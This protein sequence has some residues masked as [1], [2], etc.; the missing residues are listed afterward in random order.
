M[1]QEKKWHRDC[2][3][4]RQERKQQDNIRGEDMSNQGH[5]ITEAEQAAHDELKRLKFLGSVKTHGAA[6][7]CELFSY[8]RHYKRGYQTDWIMVSMWTGVHTV[9]VDGDSRTPNERVLAHFKGFTDNN[10]LQKRIQIENANKTEA[11]IMKE[12]KKIQAVVI[13]GY[14]QLME[15]E[16]SGRT[17]TGKNIKGFVVDDSFQ[18]NIVEYINNNNMEL[19]NKGN[20]NWSDRLTH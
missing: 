7:G 3:T 15:A 11:S 13:G 8:V 6:D 12:T 4:L 16:Q 18:N 9:T 14:V 5:I 19:T 20:F 2:N 10:S 17:M 1:S